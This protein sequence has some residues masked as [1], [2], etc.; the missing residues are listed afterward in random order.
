MPWYLWLILAIGLL[1][2]GVG[3]GLVND[4][5]IRFELT[6]AIGVALC[7]SV[8]VSF[9]VFK[10]QSDIDHARD[11]ADWKER[12]Q[13]TDPLKHFSPGDHS[14][15]GID[16]SGKTIIQSN[17]TGANLRGIHMRAAKV[18]DTKFTQTRMDG[19]NLVAV[20]FDGRTT[21]E[22]ADLSGSDLRDAKFIKVDASQSKSLRGAKVNSG[23]CW[24]KG[25]KKNNREIMKHLIAIPKIVDGKI[26][27]EKGREFG[28]C[29]EGIGGP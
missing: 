8:I 17:F 5:N 6:A 24:P 25:F 10:L 18:R 4:R 29:L 1:V 13:A 19:A 26:R 20:L 21:F 9:A 14:V 11:E 27:K 15:Q 12:I 7:T 23:T 22:N 3:M 28:A 16:L 2:I